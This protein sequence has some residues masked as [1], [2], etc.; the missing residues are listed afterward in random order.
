MDLIRISNNVTMNDVADRIDYFYNRANQIHDLI[1]K[2]E[3]QAK[4]E[5]TLLHR[6]QNRE[7]HELTL[8]KNA[9]VI[10]KNSA[11]WAYKNYFGHLHF[12]DNKNKNL[13]WNLDEFS[14]GK[15]WFDL[16]VNKQEE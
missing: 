5:Y 15:S 9:K 2:D 7:Y 6:E 14:Q 4:Q 1:S 16:F 8:V 11:L 12:I 3:M 10:E 13:V